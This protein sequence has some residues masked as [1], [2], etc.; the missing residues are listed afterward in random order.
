MVTIAMLSAFI[1]YATTRRP[2]I[3][4]GNLS[5]ISKLEEVFSGQGMVRFQQEKERLRQAV[6]WELKRPETES[7]IEAEQ[8]AVYLFPDALPR[9]HFE[10]EVALML[11]EPLQRKIEAAPKTPQSREWFEEMQANIWNYENPDRT[12][13]QLSFAAKK[14]IRIYD[15]MSAP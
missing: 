4:V 6:F 1:Y 5:D 9:D 2:V 13:P 3:G 8:L 14:V 10:R 15:V 12:A 11:W 7:G